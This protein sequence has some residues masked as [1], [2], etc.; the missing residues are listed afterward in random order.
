M[1]KIALIIS[2]YILLF[3]QQYIYPISTNIQFIT[4]V[5]GIILLG[6]PH[7]AADLLVA[8]QNADNGT[9]VFSKL[10]FF[11]VYLGRLFLFSA[12]IWFSPVLGIALFICFAAYHFGETD[13]YQ[14]KTDTFLGKLF[15]ISYGLVILSVILLHHF[16]DIKPLFLQFESGK[17]NI[18]IINWIDLYRYTLLSIS[19]ILFFTTTFIY[20][21]KNTNSDKNESGYFLI[22]FALILFILFN[23]PML[24]SFTFYFVIW[25]SLLSLRNIIHYLRIKDRFS[26]KTIFKQ[27]IFYSI[28]AICGVII[29]GF[30]GFMFIS[31]TAILGYLFLGLAVLTAPHMQIMHDMYRRVRM[32]G[33]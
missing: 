1:V 33:Y 5:I 21:V 8:T 29:V 30:A 4:F 24:L 7:G 3:L 25:H 12:I 15:V 10:C 16:E 27:I 26:L 14:F 23:L 31:D 28:L 11:S 9:R 13:L 32:N 17:A 6:V 18:S 19:G 20:F 2:G 22:R